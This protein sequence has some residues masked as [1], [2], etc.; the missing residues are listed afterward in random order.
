MREWTA[1]NGWLAA[2]SS[3]NILGSH[4]SARIRTVVGSPEAH[5][6]AVGL[7][8][9]L[10]GVP[11][12]FAGDELGL[13]GVN[14]EDARRPMPWHRP[15]A[16]DHETLAT[17]AALAA[18]RH[19][20]VALRR[21]GLRWAHIGEDT[22]AFLREHPEETLLVVA[23]RAP[24]PPLDLPLAVGEPVVATSDDPSATGV[25]VYRV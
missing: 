14:G 8:F 1:R 6:V 13:E 2:A 7:Q 3:W 12:V 15:D 16:W 19:D 18:V 10:P 22:L 21:G 25:T 20:H 24:G 11:M 23:R 17:Y 9:T 4:D 5:R